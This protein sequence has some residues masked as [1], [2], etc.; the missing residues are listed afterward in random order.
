MSFLVRLIL[1][2]SGFLCFP[3]ATSTASSDWQLNLNLHLL[4]Q[5]FQRWSDSTPRLLSWLDFMFHSDFSLLL[6]LQLLVS[7]QGDE[8]HIGLI[9]F[10]S[11][12]RSSWIQ[13]KP[14]LSAG[15]AVVRLLACE[16]YSHSVSQSQDVH[17]VQTA[18][19]RWWTLNWQRGDAVMDEKEPS[20]KS[21][22]S[23][24]HSPLTKMEK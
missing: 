7:S 17:T 3:S 22:T 13:Q 11:R 23:Y 21:V 1:R 4:E 19:P 24:I 14:R 12:A 9:N 5:H 2:N 8:L 15:I 16:A 20:S 18:P 10:L 6:M